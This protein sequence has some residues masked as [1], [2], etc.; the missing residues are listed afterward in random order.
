LASPPCCEVRSAR[1]G[2]GLFSDKDD[3]MNVDVLVKFNGIKKDLKTPKQ[4]AGRVWSG[5]T[6]FRYF[7]Y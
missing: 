1:G 7:I 3:D 2:R 4:R 5:T 6:G